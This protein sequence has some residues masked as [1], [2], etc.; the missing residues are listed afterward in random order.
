LG[1][2][3]LVALKLREARAC[4]A[5]R[6]YGSGVAGVSIQVTIDDLEVR[7]IFVQTHLKV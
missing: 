2:P 6:G 5:L 4:I 3:A 7:R 1:Q